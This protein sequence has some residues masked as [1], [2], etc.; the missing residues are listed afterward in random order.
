[1]NLRILLLASTCIAHTFAA[2]AEEAVEPLENEQLEIAL[3]PPEQ[4]INTA[5]LKRTKV[6]DDETILFYMRDGKIYRNDLPRECHGLRF[7][8]SF[9]YKPAVNRLC[10]VDLITVLQP[11]GSTMMRG[12][13]CGLGVFQPIPKGEAHV[14]ETEIAGK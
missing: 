13:S 5:R 14:L 2:A 12:I 7:N 9:M 4:C 11:M 3:S 10:D 8:G 6:I 1:M